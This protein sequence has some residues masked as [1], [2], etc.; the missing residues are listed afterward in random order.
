MEYQNEDSVNDKPSKRPILI[1]IGTG[2]VVASFVLYGGVL[3]VPFTPFPG[4]TK[5][6]IGT[7]LAVLGEATF[8]IGGII[9]G[10][11]VVTKYK[12][13]MN[14]LHW[15]KKKEIRKKDAGP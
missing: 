11:E 13:Y 2:L 12:K 1:K 10:K 14:P 5:I 3:L 9:L 6:I 7:T 4:K 15:F 8:W